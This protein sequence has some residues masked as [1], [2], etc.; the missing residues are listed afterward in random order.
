M[1]LMKD[2]VNRDSALKLNRNVAIAV[3]RGIRV[4]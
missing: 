2:Q 3:S 1:H 4:F